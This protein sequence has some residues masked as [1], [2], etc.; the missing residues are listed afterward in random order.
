MRELMIELVDLLGFTL[1]RDKTPDPSTLQTVLGVQIELARSLR[2][3]Q[4]H[5]HALISVDPDKAE[6]WILQLAEITSRGLISPKEAS[7]FAGRFAFL[8]HAILGPLGSSKI[9]HLYRAAYKTAGSPIT[10]DLRRELDWWRSYLVDRSPV[11]LKIRPRQRF[12][13]ILYTDATGDGD[14][15]VEITTE[16]GTF[17]TQGSVEASRRR[18]L[19]ARKTQI[20]AYEMI[21]A[22]EGI[23]R[24]SGQIANRDAILFIDNLS[25]KGSLAKGKCRKDDLQLIVDEF[26]NTCVKF[27]IRPRIIWIPSSLNISDLPS[28]R[29]DPQVG[30]QVSIGK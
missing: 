18:R 9:R 10:E 1:E 4:W 13:P 17:W 8:S 30:K 3:S 6:H 24:F 27:K 16:Q 12:V 28:R 11:S 2:R 7:K 23:V 14:I 20:I 26:V 22:L 21:A 25:A 19:K 29:K 5:Y 15:G